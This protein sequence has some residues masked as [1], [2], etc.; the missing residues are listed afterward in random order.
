MQFYYSD[1][2]KFDSPP[3]RNSMVAFFG[4]LLGVIRENKEIIFNHLSQTL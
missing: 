3:E 4:K 2:D 1:T